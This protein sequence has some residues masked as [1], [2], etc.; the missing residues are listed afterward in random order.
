M[1]RALTCTAEARPRWYGVYLGLVTDLNDP[2]GQG[3]VKVSCRGRPDP[4][5]GAY[6][7]WARLATLMGG[8][9]RG[10]WFVPDIDDEVLV[11]FEGGDPRRPYVLG[12]LWNGTTSRR[13]RWTAR[14]QRQEGDP[15]AQRREGHARRHQ[16]ARSSSWSRRRAG[17]RSRSRTGPARSRSS[18]P[19]A[20]RS[21]SRAAASR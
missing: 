4:G 5:G 18:T 2:D 6:E 12:G 7:A 20:T 11:A 15:L 3:R 8:D 9:N 17:R 14:A 16:T 19:T 10:T 13:S 21:S 1:T